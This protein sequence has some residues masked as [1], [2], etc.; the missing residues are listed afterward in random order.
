MTTLSL[1]AVLQVSI[2]LTGAET[3][4]EAHRVTTET[5]QPMVVLVGADWCPACQRMEKS[6]LPQLRRRGVLGKVA[7]AIV[8]LDRQRT[9]GR[10]LT[11]GGPIPQLVM[12]RRTNNGWKRRKLIG[13][14]SV[15]KTETFIQQGVKLNEAEKTA[16][17]A[18]NTHPSK[19]DLSSMR[20][21]PAKQL[22]MT[23]AG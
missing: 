6:V 2:L 12:Y 3:Y 15:S 8:N 9:L 1:H 19:K 11:G 21:A 14:Q 16:A 7:F 18:E 13:A 4:A 17:G 20:T 22:S 10:Q 23:P 5:G